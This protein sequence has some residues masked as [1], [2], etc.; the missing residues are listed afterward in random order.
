LKLEIGRC[1]R[2][3]RGVFIKLGLLSYS[4][5]TTMTFSKYTLLR[6]SLATSTRL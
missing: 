1:D 2:S 5:A 3:F 4:P 6:L